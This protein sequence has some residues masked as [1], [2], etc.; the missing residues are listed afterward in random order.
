VEVSTDKSAPRC[1]PRRLIDLGASEQCAEVAV[2]ESSRC[3]DYSYTC[4]SYC[5]GGPQNTVL[6]K[7]NL[8]VTGLW[9]IPRKL[10][11][12]AFEDAF[13]ITRLL[14]YRYIWIDSLCIIQDDE[15]DLEHEIL[16][17][18]HI[19]KGAALT[20]CA[21]TSRNCS[22]GFLH[23]RPD[24]SEN[25]IGLNLPG[26]REG[27]IHLDSFLWWDPPV[28]E[29]LSTRA[30]A[31]Q[32]RLLSPR[33]LEFGW[34]TSRW[35]CACCKSYSGHSQLGVEERRS[36][37]GRRSPQ[38]Q[39]YNLY[40][41]MNPPGLRH[42]P[43]K[44]EDLFNTWCSIVRAY[45]GLALTFPGDRLAAIG[46]IAAELHRVTGVQYLA[47]LWQ[48]ERLASLLQWRVDTHLH[49]LQS[50]PVISRAPSWSWPGIDGKVLIHRSEVKVAGFEILAVDVESGF[51]R[52]ANGSIEI[53]GPVRTGSWWRRNATPE[54]NVSEGLK[55]TGAGGSELL[56]LPDCYGEIFTVEKG[57]LVMTGQELTFIAVG[58]THSD[59]RIVRGL[60]LVRS[61]AAGKNLYRRIGMFQ[62]PE[63]GSFAVA[64]WD[65]MPLTVV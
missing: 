60:L 23:A 32:E 9:C 40:S 3:G 8:D 43:V 35:T 38:I 52:V 59:H 39:N 12:A 34:R 10:I 45:S 36:M 27:K 4:L 16:Q 48:H 49:K 53:Q 29:P 50:R 7:R 63:R 19:Y 37:T 17:M 65:V 58:R 56:L 22:E 61:E 55:I 25:T 54:V 28:P 64:E 15:Q 33:L 21:S 47:G 14:G 6:S 13:K 62:V 2:T 57:D 5:W 41:F 51:G 44:V 31:Y 24:Y 26:G 30:W 11:P 1:K 20:I 46:G 18:P 42:Y